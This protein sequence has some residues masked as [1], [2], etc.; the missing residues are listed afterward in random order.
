MGVQA[1]AI[2]PPMTTAADIPANPTTAR[3]PIDTGD[4]PILRDAD[5]LPQAKCTWH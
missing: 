5:R 4:L 2:E 3:R 1:Q